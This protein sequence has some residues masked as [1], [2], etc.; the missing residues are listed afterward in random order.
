[1]SAV[2]T[3]SWIERPNAARNARSV[4]TVAMLS[5]VGAVVVWNAPTT[6]ISVGRSR[7]SVT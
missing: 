7:K 4:N 2:T 1:M 3:E 6:T 5:S